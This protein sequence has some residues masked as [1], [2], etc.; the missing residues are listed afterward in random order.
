MKMANFNDLTMV[1][2][3]WLMY[4]FGNFLMSIEYYDYRL[5]LYALNGQFIEVFENI[6]THQVESIEVACY[7]SLDKYL[8]RIV[9]GNIKRK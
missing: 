4:E 7:G 1:D 2:K 9:L 3:A 8:N 6:Y 5:H